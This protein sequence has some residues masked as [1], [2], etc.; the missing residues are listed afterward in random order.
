MWAFTDR[1]PKRDLYA[2]NTLAAASRV[3][4]SHNSELATRALNESIR[5]R[6]ESLKMMSS[7]SNN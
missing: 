1:D 2:A 3:L 4:K 5:L 6:N 7:S